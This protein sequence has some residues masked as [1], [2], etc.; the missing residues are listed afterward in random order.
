MVDI[1]FCKVKENKEKKGKSGDCMQP[2]VHTLVEWCSDSWLQSSCSAPSTLTPLINRLCLILARVAR[3]PSVN[4][5]YKPEEMLGLE[6][7]AY[8]LFMKTKVGNTFQVNQPVSRKYSTN[9]SILLITILKLPILL[10]AS[11]TLK[12][13]KYRYPLHSPYTIPKPNHNANF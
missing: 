4:V 10:S 9:W 6:G 11:A 3:E 12:E 1:D 5:T 13:L 2:K 8:H 7:V